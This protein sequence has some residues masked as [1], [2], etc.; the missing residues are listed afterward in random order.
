MAQSE[1]L[2]QVVRVKVAIQSKVRTLRDKQSEHEKESRV[3]KCW[4]K[5][6]ESRIKYGV[7][8]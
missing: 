5:S 4:T 8:R 7:R 2:E 1:K 6:R 3:R